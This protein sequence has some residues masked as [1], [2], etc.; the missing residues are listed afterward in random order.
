MSAI[1]EMTEPKVAKQKAEKGHPAGLYLLFFTE[2]WE[3]FSYY[4]MRAILIL[5]LTKSYLEGG[6][7]MDPAYAPILYGNFTGL[8]YFTPLIGGW[9]ADK[10]IG[11]RH[12]ITIGGLLMMCGQFTL[13]AVNT[14]VGLYIGLFLL[15]IGNGFF[16]PNISTLVG[17]LYKEGDA[18]RDSAFSIFYMGINLGALLAPL[19]I[20]L[21]TDNIFATK[22]AHGEIVSYGYRYGFLAAGIGMLLGQI[23]FNT[24]AQRYL[25]DLGKKP[26]NNNILE[27]EVKAPSADDITPKQSRDRVTVIFILVCFA[28]F[29]WAGFEQAGSSLSL[30]TDKFVD[31]TVFGW[32]IP[33]AFFQS[34]NPLFIVALAPLFAGFWSS[35]LGKKL[36]TPLKMG[37]GMII[38]GIGFFFMLGAVAERG[39]DVADTAIKANIM[40]LVMTYLLHTIGELC[41]SPVGLSV[42][43][44]LS[45]PKLASLLMAV[46]LLS[47][48]V[49]NI[50]GGQLAAV[51]E[52]LGAGKIFLYISILVICCG[53]LLI[54]LNKKIVSMMH[55]LR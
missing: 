16:K 45:P 55:G 35:R 51:V 54:T 48:F 52:Q 6:L 15:I 9:L 24:L 30:Y 49:A 40:W 21:L 31:R 8:V 3:R 14:H 28:I 12:A 36:T 17:G 42:V 7:A 22:G 41:L 25:G 43:T 50:L 26:N 53:L 11:K 33:T 2:M 39:G 27:V 10:Y 44:K 46:W 32:E 38:L 19:V 47:S 5:Y 1:A 13:F 37:L 20:G 23:L 34:V 4:G 18:R 29:F